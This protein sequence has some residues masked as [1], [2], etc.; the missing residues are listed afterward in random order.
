MLVGPPASGKTTLRRRIVAAGWPADQV[1]S[2]D[3]LRRHLRARA[4]SSDSPERFTVAAL[5]VAGR[6]QEALLRTRRGYL[7]DATSLRRRERV[8]HARAAAGAGLPAVALLLA[9]RD[10]LVRRNAARPP[11][12]RVPPDVLARAAAR[13][14]L[15]SVSLLR[16]EGF[17]EVHLVGDPTRFVVQA[18]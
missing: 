9:E 2:L 7:V 10:D 14:A 16:E 6:R 13:R 17:A 15:L 11:D 4:G 12:E 18:A 3:E 8:A 5:G 1:V